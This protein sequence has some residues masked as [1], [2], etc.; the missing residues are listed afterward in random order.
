[1]TAITIGVW[2]NPPVT[3]RLRAASATQFFAI[4]LNATVLPVANR[5]ARGNNAAS[6]MGM[7]PAQ[8]FQ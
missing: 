1:M 7:A 3:A 4:T 5:T 2:L 6:E 8:D